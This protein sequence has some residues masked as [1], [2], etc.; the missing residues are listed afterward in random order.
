MIAVPG[1]QRFGSIRICVKRHAV[2]FRDLD[3]VYANGGKDDLPV[4]Q[5]IPAGECTRWID[6]RGGQRNIRR[7]VLRYD[8]WGNS[9][10]RALI[11]AWGR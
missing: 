6:L 1:K 5:V 2:H 4:R 9:G 7:I 10:P 3:V 11:E 8:T